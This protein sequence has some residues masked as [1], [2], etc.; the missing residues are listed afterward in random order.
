MAPQKSHNWTDILFPPLQ[1]AW[2][3][4]PQGAGLAVNWA[5][6]QKAEQK[7]HLQQALR[8]PALHFPPQ[9]QWFDEPAQGSCQPGLTAERA[10]QLSSKP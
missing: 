1:F 5:I 10:S 7:K 3:V 2:L 9:E 8:I 4:Q 6:C